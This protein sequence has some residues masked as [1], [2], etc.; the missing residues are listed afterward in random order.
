M[1]NNSPALGCAAVP[2]LMNNANT[3]ETNI[4]RFGAAGV[5]AVGTTTVVTGASTRAAPVGAELVGTWVVT[6]NACGTTACDGRVD[7]F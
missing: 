5:T 2:L 1:P 6:A 3:S 4:P 7:E